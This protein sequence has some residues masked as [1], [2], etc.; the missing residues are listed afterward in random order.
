MASSKELIKK[1]PVYMDIIPLHV[2]RSMAARR[3]VHLP[4]AVGYL[5]QRNDLR[6][7]DVVVLQAACPGQAFNS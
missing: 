6:H 4:A 5:G 3:L 2:S 7:N 1:F